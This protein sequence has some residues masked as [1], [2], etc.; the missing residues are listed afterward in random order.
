MR[1]DIVLFKRKEECCG[2]GACAAIC[3]KNAI[4]MV[5]DEEG[6]A[7]PQINYEICVKCKICL[8][9][10]PLKSFRNEDN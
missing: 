7:Y 4:T 1:E 9:V 8:G 3:S 10:C 6:F 5:D 2:C